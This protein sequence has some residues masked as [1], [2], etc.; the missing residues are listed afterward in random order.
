MDLD[1]SFG[2]RGP[3]VGARLADPDTS[4]WSRPLPPSDL[5]PPPERPYSAVRVTVALL[6]VGALLGA[7]GF[8]LLLRPDPPAAV[9]RITP[10]YVPYVDVTL[11]P[12]YAFQDPTANPVGEVALGFVVAAKDAPCTPSWGG[13]Y[14]LA[15]A[16]S[17][18]DVDRRVAQLTKQGG[19]ALVSFGGQANTELAVGCTDER[20][21]AAA[22]GTVI[23]RYPVRTVDFDIEGAA[24]GDAAANVR[25]ARAIATLQR[26]R[27]AA[28]RPLGV[29]LTL[30]V[31]TDG[32]TAEGLAAIAA[33]LRAGVKL[34]GVNAMAMDF[35]PVKG[36]GR[37]H[38]LKATTDALTAA[39]GQLESVTR[40]AGLK[41]ASAQIWAHLGVTVMI[42]RNDVEGQ[43]FTL[44]DAEGLKRFVRTH[45]LSRVST[46]SI[47]RD[48]QCGSVF[49]QISVLSNTCSGVR[50]G[51][52]AFTRILMRLP[53]TNTAAAQTLD[54]G[55]VPQV[56]AA[57]TDDPD[58]S[59]YPIWSPTAPYGAGYKVVWHRNVYQAKWYSQNQAPD[60][61]A[62][63]SQSP[64]L[65]L[66]PVR[67]RDKPM[68]L[69]VTPAPGLPT[70]SDT[71]VYHAGD[72]VRYHGLP[73]VARQ[74]VKTV[75][76]S[77]T[78][79]PSP[80]SPWIPMFRA[81]GEPATGPGAPR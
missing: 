8:L 79:P 13:A 50:Q 59:P 34:T 76:P 40:S 68:R 58:T 46:W 42:G 53:G 25:R 64:W 30:P 70:W 67:A 74:Y 57:P 38:M 6:L 16:G 20:R 21:L 17:A 7:A 10:I 72:R 52:L 51:P 56:V 44:A 15:D 71:T 73:F 43:V 39:H 80:S 77:T 23:D 47:N 18:I 26:R 31:A 1:G 27:A 12:T 78:L 62:A 24:L 9:A 3:A 33:T 66:G 4:T 61:P 65:L 32:F 55:P 69:I 29:W 54:A 5:G 60:G 75:V 11:T 81:A 35:S 37:R 49:A 14:S 41:L 2:G 28:H 19:H 48:A 22:Y 63:A 45:R 36:G